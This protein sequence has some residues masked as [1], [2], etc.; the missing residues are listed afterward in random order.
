MLNI[1]RA[2]VNKLRKI[3]APIIGYTGI[4]F[5]Y[6]ACF[7]GWIISEI[8]LWGGGL[9]FLVAT[10]FT[11]YN[12]WGANLATE[13]ILGQIALPLLWLVP[14]GIIGRIMAPRFFYATRYW[15]GWMNAWRHV[16]N[17]PLKPN[18]TSL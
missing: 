3:V 11:L 8:T 14:L 7:T 6:Y 12:A 9:Y 1:K 2:L 18:P 10:G 5:L 13:T 16:R 15:G 17:K 4:P